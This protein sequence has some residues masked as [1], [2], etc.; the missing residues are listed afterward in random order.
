MLEYDLN[1]NM[2]RACGGERG[3]PCLAKGKERGGSKEKIKNRGATSAAKA[4][5][6]V[7]PRLIE[8]AKANLSHPGETRKGCG[9]FYCGMSAEGVW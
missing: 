1:R 4:D 7:H 2:I 8:E 5:A 9:K 6:G 3:I